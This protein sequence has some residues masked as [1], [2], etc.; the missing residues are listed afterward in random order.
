MDCRE[1]QQVL[2]RYVD[3][4]LTP[5]LRQAAQVHL[6]ECAECRE[7]VRRELAWQSAVRTG[8]SY[9]AAPEALRRRIAALP[10][11]D[12]AAAR[13]PRRQI[14]AMAASLLLAIGLSSGTTLFVAERRAE[15]AITEQLV[16]SHVRSLMVE[17][18][19]DVV[20]SDQHTVKPWFH[21][22]LDYAPPVEDLAEA[23]FPLV[24]GR[25]DYIDHHPVAALIY[26]R[27][28]HPINLFVLPTRD[29]DAAPVARIDSGYNLLQWTEKGMRYWAI[30][31]LN[32]AEL[33]AFSQAV[34]HRS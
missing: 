4:E 32:A 1:L 13:L 15:P 34:R 21:G 18:L 17:H 20:S 23:G 2:H 16:A 14:W 26:R 12:A 31:D 8:A 19:T 27:A 7:L 29:A 25:L 6:D 3:D 10:E 28:Q 9:H 30:S 24:G 22:R 33:A 5:E 11:R